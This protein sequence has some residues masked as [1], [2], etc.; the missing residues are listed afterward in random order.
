MTVAK[1]LF[2]NFVK[3]AEPQSRSD[4]TPRRRGEAA[5]ICYNH[6]CLHDR[7][8]PFNYLLVIKF[9]KFYFYIVSRASYR[10]LIFFSVCGQKKQ[11]CPM[12]LIHLLIWY[13]TQYRCWKTFFKLIEK[14]KSY[15]CCPNIQDINSHNRQFLK[16][17]R[18]QWQ[19]KGEAILP[20]SGI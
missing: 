3:Y 6:D 12:V 7:E 19:I 4:C 5:S 15:S 13:V 1:R 18:L 11:E 9:F 17:L 20:Y 14:K 2:S 8:Y 10:I 16:F